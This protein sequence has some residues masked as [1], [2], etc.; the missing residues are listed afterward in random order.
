MIES[1]IAL[2]LSFLIFWGIPISILTAGFIL[3]YFKPKR[4]AITGKI[5]IVLGI[6]ELS[7]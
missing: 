6:L 5:L 2:F 3:S 4:R 1:P 7:L